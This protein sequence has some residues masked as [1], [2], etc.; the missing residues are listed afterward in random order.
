MSNPSGR[1]AIVGIGETAVGK[2]PERT[3]LSLHLEAIRLA[4]ADSGL[5]KD[6]ID[7][8]LTNQPLHDPSRSYAAYLAAQAGLRVT[9]ATDLALGGATP[10]A[11]AQVATAAIEAGMCSRV[12]CVHARHERSWRQLAKHG[13]PIRNGNEEFEVPYGAAAAPVAYAMAASRHMAEYGTTSRQLGAVAV[14][15]RR[16]ACL[17][18]I[19][20]MREPITL[21]DHEASPWIVAPLRLLDCC[22]L[23]DGGGAYVVTGAAGARDLPH[24]PVY[25][26]GMGQ[27]HPHSTLMDAPSLTTWGGAEASRRAYA[28]AGLSARDVDFA[29]IYDCFTITT[30]ITLE[31]YG[32]CPK[33]AGGEFVAAGRI[34]MGGALP[35]NTH[36]GLLSQAH[37][38]GM[39]HVT[40]AVKQL[41]GRLPPERQVPGARVG[42]VSGNGG[43]FSTH[44]TLIL[45]SEPTR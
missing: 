27:R 30:L 38:E 39:L 1:C 16:H 28:M 35:V 11:M 21:E 25:I 3:T 32:F 40:E 15:A 9:F 8:L 45:G 42:I 26:L 10:V 34:E 18:P 12:V 17:N 37:I 20:Q 22:L 24:P 19:A 7:G 43:Q 5:G 4:I 2:L 33:G 36:G 6:A 14:A 31:D 41:R 23:S 29:E 13:Q 44:A